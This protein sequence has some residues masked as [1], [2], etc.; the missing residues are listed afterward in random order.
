[1]VMLRFF[2][3]RANCFFCLLHFFFRIDGSVHLFRPLAGYMSG[4]CEEMNLCSLADY[5][6]LNFVFFFS[7]TVLLFLVSGFY[8]YTHH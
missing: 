8:A 6:C 5:Y 4:V 1:M 3:T 7:A 2:V